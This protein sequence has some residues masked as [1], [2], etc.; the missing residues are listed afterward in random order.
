[1]VSSDLITDVELHLLAD[2]HRK[3]DA[4]VTS[5]LHSQADQGSEGVTVP[6]TRSKKKSGM[7]DDTITGMP[8]LKKFSE[9]RKI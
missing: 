5:L 8:L 6:G 7:P 2:V 3:Y 4:T 9:I 1:M